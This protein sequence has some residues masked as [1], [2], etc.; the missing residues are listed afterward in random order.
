M[1]DGTA[2]LF[3]RNLNAVVRQIA[4]S[5][6]P[7]YH[8][9]PCR[10]DNRA[11]GAK[12]QIRPSAPGNFLP[13]SAVQRAVKPRGCP[14]D[15]HA[16]LQGATGDDQL[17]PRAIGESRNQVRGAACL[18]APSYR[19]RADTAEPLAKTSRLACCPM[20]SKITTVDHCASS[21]KRS[22]Q[23]GCAVATRYIRPKR[24]A[25]PLVSCRARKKIATDRHSSVVKGRAIS[26]GQGR[27]LIFG[28]QIVWCGA[29]LDL[30]HALRCPVRC[31]MTEILAKRC[32]CKSC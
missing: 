27:Q 13:F 14:T 22:C 1:S 5:Q 8:G 32:V 10:P 7:L 19:E 12:G 2:W 28:R 31:I 21:A 4:T 26:S 3:R 16:G 25:M 30:L 9:K 23:S 24:E 11:H 18:A 6:W 29:C 17:A 20:D 15:V